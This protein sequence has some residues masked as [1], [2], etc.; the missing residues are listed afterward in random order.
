MILNEPAATLAV[1]NAMYPSSLPGHKTSVVFVFLHPIP[2]GENVCERSQ[3][4]GFDSCR[5][6]TIIDMF[7]K[8]IRFSL[9]ILACLFYKI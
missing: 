4:G 9:I 5:D 2:N 8:D 6:T 1:F 3:G 7:F